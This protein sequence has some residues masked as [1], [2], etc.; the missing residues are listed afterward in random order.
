MTDK[1]LEI[2]AALPI[3]HQDLSVLS[4]IQDIQHLHDALNAYSGANGNTG[5]KI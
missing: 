4:E 1:N 2:F 5:T 3:F